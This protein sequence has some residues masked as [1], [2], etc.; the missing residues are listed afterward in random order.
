MQVLYCVLFLIDHCVEQPVPFSSVRLVLQRTEREREREREIEGIT[1]SANFFAR[2]KSRGCKIHLHSK[3]HI[4]Q[5][6]RKGISID[7]REFEGI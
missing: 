6:V 5:L 3:F 7:V 4:Q 2:Y 1:S